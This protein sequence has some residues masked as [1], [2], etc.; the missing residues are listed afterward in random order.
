MILYHYQQ[1]LIHN[2]ILY[3]IHIAIIVL[4]QYFHCMYCEVVCRAIGWFKTGSI[5]DG[6]FFSFLDCSISAYPPYNDWDLLPRSIL[7]SP[8]VQPQW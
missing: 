2:F 8:V 7:K 5:R 1:R 3:G 6:I 4:V